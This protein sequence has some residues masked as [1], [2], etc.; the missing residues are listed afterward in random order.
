MCPVCDILLL[1]SLNPVIKEPAPS[2]GRL[3]RAPPDPG[4]G[5]CIELDRRHTGSL[6]NV[7]WPSKTLPS[8]S[9]APE[10]PPPSLLEIEPA[11]PRWNED[12]MKP[13]MPFEPGAR[14][15]AIM[16]AQIIGNHKN[17]A[18]RVIGF[19]V[20]KQGNIVLRVARG[21]T[22]S[23]LLAI[24]HPQRSIHP[25]FLRS[26]A[27]IQLCFD[28]MACGRPAWSGRKA[29]GHYWPEFVGADG[30]RPPRRDRVVGD[31]RRPFGTKS[32]SSLV[33]QLCV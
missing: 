15:Q 1:C 3:R 7:R 24:A 6:L 30:R 5:P 9:I 11:C 4:L 29:A 8:Q 25:G 33:P 16:T 32:R 18:C 31:D 27:V 10:K 19:D 13:R 17:V 12:V 26:T 2:S 21:G 28:P 22:A 14:L 20:G 23:Q